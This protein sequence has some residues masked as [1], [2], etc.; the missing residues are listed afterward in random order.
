MNKL[1]FFLFVLVSSIS[2]C[3]DI[4]SNEFEFDITENRMLLSSDVQIKSGSYSFSSEKAVMDIDKNKILI[5]DPFKIEYLNQIMRGEKMQLDNDN[6]VLTANNFELYFYKYTLTGEQVEAK[7]GDVV[8]DK[9]RI[10]SCQNGKSPLFYLRSDKVHVYPQ[11]GFLVAFNSFFHVLGV[12]ILYFP[13]YFMGDKRY[14]IFANN[15][16]V[17]E[18]GSNQVEGA[19]AREN[20]P[21]YFNEANNGYIHLAYVEKFGF[22]VGVQHYTLLDAGKHK[23]SAGYFYAPKLIQWNFLYTMALFDEYERDKYFLSFLFNQEQIAK[24]NSNIYFSYYLKNNEIINN[25]FVDIKPGWKVSSIL[26]IN[27]HNDLQAEYEM[28]GIQENSLT[29]NNRIAYSAQLFSDYKFKD[30]Q[31]NNILSYIRYDYPGFDNLLRMQ[32]NIIL[33]YPVSLMLFTMDYEHM[34]LFSGSSP[35]LYD[36]Y[37]IDPMDK[38]T[39][40]AKFHFNIFDFEYKIKKRINEDFYYNRRY[41]FTLPYEKCLDFKIFWED[42]EKVF[43]FVLQI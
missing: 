15:T 27:E 29:M 28:A 43:G 3:Y 35:F 16:L 5:D 14:G 24:R 40:S 18:F 41:E 30:L 33:Q 31:F 32:N 22:K 8:M 42:V 25:Q 7:A 1:I 36:V 12:P 21:Y 10:T 23:I 19:Y 17:P 6:S 20:L 4:T 39:L 2:F 13:A 11:L 26:N 38:I 34:F 37:Q 9:V